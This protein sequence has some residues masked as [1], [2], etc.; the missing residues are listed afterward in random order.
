MEIMEENGIRQHAI[1]LEA[2][3]VSA[4]TNRTGLA[5]V[6]AAAACMVILLGVLYDKKKRMSKQE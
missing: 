5:L 4:E 2:M 3:K 6:G 1:N